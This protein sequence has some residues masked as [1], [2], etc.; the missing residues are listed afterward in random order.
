MN[1]NNTNVNQNTEPAAGA[2][3]N[4]QQ[5]TP[6]NAN[7][8]AATTTGDAAGQGANQPQAGADG[9]P[10][11]PV[12][13]DFSK[14]QMPEGYTLDEAESKRF[15][16]VIKD[17]GLTN[18]QAGSIV[19]FGTEYGQRLVDAVQAEHQQMIADWGENA[20]KELGA[21]FDKTVA[22]CGSAIEHMKD[23]APGLR[24]ALDETG[25]GNRIEIVRVLAK[26][27]EMLN[28]DPGKAAG[29]NAGGAQGTNFKSLYPN[30]NFDK[31]RA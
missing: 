6:A 18:E 20:K 8:P 3:D 25:A 26:L 22:L 11:Q 14:V 2:P 23:V 15:L 10:N 17:T 30:T 27:G 12:Q 4:Q 9:Q 1:D 31:Y 7:T 19:K 13:Y 16:E 21:D 29:A 24:Q 28:G 5:Q